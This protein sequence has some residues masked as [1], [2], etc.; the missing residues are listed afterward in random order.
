MEA[1]KVL[2]EGEFAGCNVKT[3]H[4]DRMSTFKYT[5]VLSVDNLR[6]EQLCNENVKADLLRTCT[7][8]F[9]R[10]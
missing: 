9:K 5:H 6:Y 3:Y 4:V 2:K 7:K 10:K 8:S 1:I